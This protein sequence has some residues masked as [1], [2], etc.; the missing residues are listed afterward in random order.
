MNP[1]YLS[2]MV[3]SGREGDSNGRYLGLPLG[4][5]YKNVKT[6]DPVVNRFERRLAR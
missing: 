4:A 6:R 5:N 1:T 2:E 3:R